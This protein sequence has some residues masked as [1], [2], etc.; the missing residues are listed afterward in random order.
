MTRSGVSRVRAGRLSISPC[1]AK[2]RVIVRKQVSQEC[3]ALV[4]QVFR[5]GRSQQGARAI[6]SAA[7]LHRDG[8]ENPLPERLTEIDVVI[9]IDDEP[10]LIVAVDDIKIVPLGCQVGTG[11]YIHRLPERFGERFPKWLIVGSEARCAFKRNYPGHHGV[12]QDMRLETGKSCCR[13]NGSSRQIVVERE[14][15]QLDADIASGADRL[16][17]QRSDIESRVVDQI[18]DS[19]FPSRHDV[20]T[21]PFGHTSFTNSNDERAHEDAGLSPGVTQKYRSG[22]RL[23][24]MYQFGKAES[25]VPDASG[26]E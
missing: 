18:D 3:E 26:L 21:N 20:K 4:W 5:F 11:P 6:R 16:K 10:G 25:R 24:S 9:V 2:R 14:F 17:K 19:I 23:A 8:K 15:L 13:D 22:D 12:N 1:F 7:R